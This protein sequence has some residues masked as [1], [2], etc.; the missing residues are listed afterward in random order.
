MTVAAVQ[1]AA[2]PGIPE[3]YEAA[4][5]QVWHNHAAARLTLPAPQLVEMD[6][7]IGV[8]GEGFE[9]IFG[10][11]KGLVSIRYN[12]VQLLDDTVR[13]NFWRAPP[14]TTRAAQSLSR[15]PSG[16]LPVSMPAVIT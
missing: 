1:R 12:G 14:T 9:Y 10:R 13:P 3:G 5:G 7:N 6:Y 16:K 4:L 11:G 15:L 8:K 2:L